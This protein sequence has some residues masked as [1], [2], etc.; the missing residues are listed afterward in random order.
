MELIPNAGQV[1]RQAWSVRFMV[2]SALFAGAEAVLSITDL[3]LDRPW[4]ALASAMAAIGAVVTR[5]LAQPGLT[6]QASADADKLV[7]DVIATAVAAALKATATKPQ[8]AQ[9]F[10][11]QPSGKV[12]VYDV[13]SGE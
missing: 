9:T 10:V 11:V 3:G 2:L 8:A 12:E 1:A 13:A 6:P 4:F 7:R 5:F